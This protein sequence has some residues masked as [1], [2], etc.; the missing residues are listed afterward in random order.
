MLKLLLILP[1][2]LLATG[3]GRTIAED[4]IEQARTAMETGDYSQGSLLLLM[5]CDDLHE[6][7]MYLLRMLH[8]QERNNLMEMVYAWLAIEDIET[9]ELFVKEAAYN[10]LTTTLENA[11]IRQIDIDE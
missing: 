8:H 7:S 10:L 11:I 4:A 1:I 3:C 9:S 6:Q 5:G 2:L